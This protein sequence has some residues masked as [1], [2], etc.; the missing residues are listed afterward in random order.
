[1]TC[2]AYGFGSLNRI[3][4]V[5]VCKFASSVI[6]FF[7]KFYITTVTLQNVIPSGMSVCCGSRPS[8][9]LGNSS[10]SVQFLK[11]NFISSTVVPS[12][13]ILP[14]F[15]YLPTDAQDICF[16]R[17][18]KFTLKFTLKELRHVSV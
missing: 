3:S 9:L 12:I 15:L 18:L 6:I 10:Q 4:Y 5:M 17:I 11:H 8:F 13:L 16:K 14:K 1:M 2:A 7:A